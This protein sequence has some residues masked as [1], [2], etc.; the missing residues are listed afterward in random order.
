MTHHCPTDGHVLVQ[1]DPECLVCGQPA[2][3]GEP[4]GRVLGVR[5]DPELVNPADLA[6]PSEWGPCGF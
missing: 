6:Q 2:V 3:T 5:F 4:I 1:G